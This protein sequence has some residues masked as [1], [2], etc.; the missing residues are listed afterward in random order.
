MTLLQ[1]LL[2]VTRTLS[3]NES[4]LKPI[5][6]KRRSNKMT[7]RTRLR[8]ADKP[9]KQVRKKCVQREQQP[10]PNAEMQSTMTMQMKMILSKMKLKTMCSLRRTKKTKSGRRSPKRSKS[11]PML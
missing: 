11:I 9:N 1:G 4:N 7:Y 6:L 2:E 3:N 8:E 5:R 10:E